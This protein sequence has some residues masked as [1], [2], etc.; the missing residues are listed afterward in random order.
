ML[1]QL[2]LFTLA[3]SMTDIQ[4]IGSHNSYHAGLAPKEMA[5]LREK[6]PKAA[7]ALDYTHPPLTKQLEMGVRKFELDI[8]ADTKGGR[9]AKPAF[10]TEPPYELASAM[11][12]PGYKVLHVQDLDYRS[13]CQPLTACLSEIR[14]WSKAHPRH[15]PIYI[16]LETKSGTPR[17]GQ[18]T[19]PE[20]I[21]AAL[22]DALDKEILS[23]FDRKQVVTP[24]DVRG[25]SATL[26]AAVLSRGWPSLESARGKVVFLFDQE[27]ITALYAE[28]HPSLKGRIVFTNATPGTPEAAF[29]KMN[30]PN[31][32]RIPELVKLGYLIRTRSD[33]E[34]RTM[35][36]AALASGAT[37]ISSDYY[38]SLHRK[39]GYF[40]D[41]GKGIARCNPVRASKCTAV[42]TTE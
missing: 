17:P 7:E 10:A 16:M 24:D 35:K 6:N 20:P 38:Y 1:S 26:E 29:I 11:L 21:T 27:N 22:L 32:P 19:T 13:S 8:F 30:D 41:F 14:T 12:K 34:G 36:D 40:I 39:D 2:L 33:A 23:V 5:A 4:V 42:S 3:Q 28:G 9:Y 37:I 31:S 25:N 15:L 18:M